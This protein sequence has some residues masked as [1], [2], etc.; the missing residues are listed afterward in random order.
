MERTVEEIWTTTLQD[1]RSGSFPSPYEEALEHMLHVACQLGTWTLSSDGVLTPEDD[2]AREVLADL[3]EVGR[4][5]FTEPVWVHGSEGFVFDPTTGEVL[6]TVLREEGED[7]DDFL[8]SVSLQSHYL[9]VNWGIDSSD[10]HQAERDKFAEALEE[11]A[12]RV[13]GGAAC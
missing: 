1:V 12:R 11:K 13:R 3:Q 2:L 8:A 9:R 7:A 5:L 10:F 6:V 4:L